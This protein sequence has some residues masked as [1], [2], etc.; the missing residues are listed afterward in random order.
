MFHIYPVPGGNMHH[1][2][3]FGLLGQ[4]EADQRDSASLMPLYFSCIFKM[5]LILL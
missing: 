4:G 3:T 5:H 1:V 2:Q